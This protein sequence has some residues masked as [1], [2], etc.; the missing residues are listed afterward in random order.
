MNLIKNSTYALLLLLLSVLVACQ[1]DDEAVPENSIVGSWRL[2][3]GEYTFNDL[4]TR[5]Y[6]AQIFNQAGLMPTDDDLDQT[7]ATFEQN[8]EDIGDGTIFEFQE[9]GTFASQTPDGNTTGTW[10]I[11]S[12]DQLVITEGPSSVN[13][14]I[15]SLSNSELRLLVEEEETIDFSIIGLSDAEP[16]TIG[17]IFIFNKQ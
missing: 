10:E 16:V 2:S 6:F 11:R 17:V 7:V 4:N 5:D 9:G 3:D 14:I 15:S 1:D 8:L 13:F 12:D